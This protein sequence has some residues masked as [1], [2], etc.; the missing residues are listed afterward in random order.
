VSGILAEF[1]TPPGGIGRALELLAI[2][3]RGDPDEI[4]AAGDL[5]DLPRPWEPTTCPADLRESVWDWCDQVAGWLNHDY[6]WRPTQTIP[7]CWPHHP[8]L[9]RELAV[10]AFLRHAAEEATSPALMEEWHRYT[11]PLFIDRMGNRLGESGCRTGKHVDWPAQARHAAYTSTQAKAERQHAF[12]AD[13]HPV[14]ALHA[15]R[16]P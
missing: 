11:L 2:L 3:R 4:A 12:Y 5:A 15:S 7:P 1:P 6:A 8:H 10:L 13:T 9:A 16:R 14:T